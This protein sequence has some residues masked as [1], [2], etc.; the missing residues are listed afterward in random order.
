MFSFYV[1]FFFLF[2]IVINLYGHKRSMFFFYQD[3]A[4]ILW[5][6]NEFFSE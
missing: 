4:T 5:Y 1:L 3:E 6:F 2:L